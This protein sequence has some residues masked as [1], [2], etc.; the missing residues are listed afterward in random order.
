LIAAR[1]EV[2]VDELRLGMYVIELDRPWLE[3]PFP[4]QG[5][6]I[7]SDEQ[8]AEIK[9]L[10]RLVY[11]DPEREEWRSAAVPGGSLESASRRSVQP[12]QKDAASARGAHPAAQTTF[13]NELPTANAARLAC[14]EA[15]R[16]SYES[17]T[18]GGEID[19]A[20]L[21]SA[22]SSM[23]ESIQ[24]NPDALMLLNTLRGK[25]GYELSRALDT[26]ILMITFA[27]FLQLPRAELELLGLAGLLLDA[28]KTRIPDAILRKQDVLTEDEYGIMKDHVRYSVEAVRR[29][30]GL[31]RGLDDIILLHHE[32][33]DGSGYPRGLR[34]DQISLHGALAGLVDSFSA[35][36]SCRLYAEQSSASNALALLFKLRGRLFHEALVE[37]FIQ[38]IGIYPVGSFVELS[39]GEV[40]IVIAQNLVRR[41][42]PRVIVVLD[43]G[44]RPIALPT[45]IDLVGEHKARNGEVYRIRRTLA[46]EKLPIDPAEFF[47]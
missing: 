9:S 36:T 32:R 11:V 8:I 47:L 26:S 46:K 29:T 35:L 39:T 40:A 38:C 28:G 31:P 42:Q 4:F 25:G 19:A 13:E 27:R 33:Q 18:R 1:K 5:F 37:Q 15:L 16:V 12:S 30:R 43:S 10:C 24:R 2:P 3:T 45:V 34:G 14:E 23:A 21:K 7:T 41:L 20:I 6:P 22:V 44:W 17:L